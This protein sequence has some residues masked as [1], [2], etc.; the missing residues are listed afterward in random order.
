MEASDPQQ[1]TPGPWFAVTD[2]SLQD[3]HGNGPVGIAISTW[4]DD[5]V[6]AIAWMQEGTEADAR[7]IA[8]APE[9]ADALRELHDFAVTTPGRH[10]DRSIQ[11]FA[12]ASELLKR[13]GK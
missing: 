8:V 10:Q 5:V 12:K 7:L 3:E 2:T 9:L 4:E 1:H 6:D 13:I 11:A